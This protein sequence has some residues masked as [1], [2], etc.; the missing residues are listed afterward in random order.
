MTIAVLTIIVLALVIGL[1]IFVFSLMRRSQ[2]VV[3]DTAE[4][5]AAEKDRVV[6]V[7]DQG[8]PVMESQ[9]GFPDEPRDASGFENVLGEGLEDLHPGGED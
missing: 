2:T 5:R 3:P 9:D 1:G 8:R 6:A 7:D 4:R